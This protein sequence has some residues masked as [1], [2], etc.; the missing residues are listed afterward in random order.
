LRNEAGEDTHQFS[1][2]RFEFASLFRGRHENQVAGPGQQAAVLEGKVEE[3]R[4]HLAGEFDRDLV[5]EIEGFAHRQFVEDLGRSLADQRRHGLDAGAGKHRRDD[6]ALGVV[7]G[8]VE[9]DEAGGAR[10][11]IAIENGDS[12][13]LRGRGKDLVIAVDG[14]NVVEP[15]HRP[16]GAEFALGRVVNRIL[17]AQALEPGPMAV[18]DEMLDIGHLKL[19]QRHRPR[20]FARIPGEVDRAVGHVPPVALYF[21]EHKPAWRS[22]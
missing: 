15:G 10:R 11:L 7:L 20:A 19:I 13:Q 3:G 5:D 22:A 21:P 2:A 1:L 12:A 8:R 4:Q 16:I 18:G 17:C 6:L 14:D 9:A